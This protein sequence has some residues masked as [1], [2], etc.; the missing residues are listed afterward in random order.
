MAL[1][2]GG[3]ALYLAQPNLEP[4]HRG[5]GAVPGLSP[6]PPYQTGYEPDAPGG[7][8]PDGGGDAA[9]PAFRPGAG[10]PSGE[11]AP[12]PLCLCPLL[13]VCQHGAE[14]AWACR[15][16]PS[17][18]R[19]TMIAGSSL[20]GWERGIPG[21]LSHLWNRDAGRAFRLLC[22]AEPALPPWP[23]ARPTGGPPTSSL[24]HPETVPPSI[25]YDEAL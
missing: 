6:V 13:P 3:P 7:A 12:G 18:V 9:G 8:V 10:V 22:P 5:A 19:S 1:D 25:R 15:T 20:T 4:G 23:R 16:G 21:R 11:P 17:S 2:P 14:T 24:Y